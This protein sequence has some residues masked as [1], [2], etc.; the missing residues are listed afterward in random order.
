MQLLQT[1][2]PLA[3]GIINFI[4]NEILFIKFL[5]QRSGDI[6]REVIHKPAG[7]GGVGAEDEAV[8]NLSVALHPVG[9]TV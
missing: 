1:A 4:T 6:I 3:D 9:R 7:Y 5:P 8:V 2:F